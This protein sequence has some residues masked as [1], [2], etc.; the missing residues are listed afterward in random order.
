MFISSHTYLLRILLMLP[1][2]ISDYH[3]QSYYKP[4]PS[5]LSTAHHLS[6]RFFLVCAITIAI[7]PLIAHYVLDHLL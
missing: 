4:L 6:N 2:N 1:K 5:H 7:A 3:M